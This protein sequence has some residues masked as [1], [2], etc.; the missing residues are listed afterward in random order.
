MH[1][2]VHHQ[3][4]Q[5]YAVFLRCLLLMLTVEAC[6]LQKKS[7][8]ALHLCQVQTN[9]A[10]GQPAGLEPRLYKHDVHQSYDAPR[11][12]DTENSKIEGY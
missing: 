11:P 4:D 3:S 8:F 10:A 7:T 9:S 2:H 1:A 12:Q 5:Y 6:Q